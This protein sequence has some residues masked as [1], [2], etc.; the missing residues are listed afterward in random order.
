[1]TLNTK[2]TTNT[3]DEL[4]ESKRSEAKSCAWICGGS[5]VLFSSRVRVTH[6]RVGRRSDADAD[7]DSLSR[8]GSLCCSFS[9]DAPISKPPPHLR[10]INT[11][12]AALLNPALGCK[13]MAPAPEHTRCDPALS[14]ITTSDKTDARPRTPPKL[15]VSLPELNRHPRSTPSPSRVVGG[16]DAHDSKRGRHAPRLY[17]D[18]RR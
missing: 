8:R 18:R 6:A 2:N 1:M 11:E 9:F 17:W 12:K 15:P 10:I 13:I 3:D 5:C 16:K 14:Q 7:G 4:R